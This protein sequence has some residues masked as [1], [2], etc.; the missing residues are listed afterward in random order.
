MI[1]TLETLPPAR[2]R[3]LALVL[4]LL[5]LLS[6]SFL[7]IDPYL[8]FRKKQQ[9]EIETLLHQ[10][11]HLIDHIAQYPY[12][13]AQDA[14]LKERF[15]RRPLY[16]EGRTPAVAAAALQERLRKM[17][18]DNGGQVLSIQTL[19]LSPEP[20]EEL[21]R[22]GVSLRLRLTTRALF[23]L[24]NQIERASPHLWVEHLGISPGRG[25][26]D[27]K[28]RHYKPLNQL[29]VTLQISAFFRKGDVLRPSWT[30]GLRPEGEERR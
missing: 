30:T 13:Q 11:Q 16:F 14:A 2:R 8:Q 12:W 3:L 5:T 9:A 22:I 27:R 15:G 1:E 29:Q 24:L 28:T 10:R 26:Y 19:T 18:E 7:V 25:Y 4:L 21:D 23:K 20:E 17:V 6:L